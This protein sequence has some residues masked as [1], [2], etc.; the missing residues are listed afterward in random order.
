MGEPVICIKEC[1]K[2]GS[3]WAGPAERDLTKVPAPGSGKN[4]EQHPGRPGT[5][6]H[7]SSKHV[8]KHIVH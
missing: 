6:F 8:G 3:H 2:T 5:G 7:C 1:G 4:I